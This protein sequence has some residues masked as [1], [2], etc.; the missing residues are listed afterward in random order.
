MSF[1]C[2]ADSSWLT[3]CVLDHWEDVVAGSLLGLVVAYFAYRQYFPSLVSPVSHR[4]HSPRVPRDE[5]VLPMTAQDA[6]RFRDS[7]DG[8]QVELIEGGAPRLGSGSQKVI[9]GE[10]ENHPSNVPVA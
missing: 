8:D 9:W 2:A 7:D 3:F 5:P 6:Q 10:G 1:L 4:P